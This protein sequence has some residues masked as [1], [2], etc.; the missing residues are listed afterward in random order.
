[1]ENNN[2]NAGQLA[3]QASE[4]KVIRKKVSLSCNVRLRP[5]LVALPNQLEEE[6]SY[7]VD[8]ILAPSGGPL[9]GV[10]GPLER[11][12]MPSIID[13]SVNDNT[14]N[15]HI[16]DYW[17]NFSNILPPDS[18]NK[19]DTT[20]GIVIK[21]TVILCSNFAID[22]FEKATRIEDKFTV[23]HN[24]L[25]NQAIDPNST[26]HAILDA[27]YYADFVKLAFIL[28]HS[29]IANRVEDREKSSKI[30]G[31]IYEK[32]IAVKAKRNEMDEFNNFL[33]NLKSLTE[34]NKANAILLSIEE[35]I[36]DTDTLEDKKLIIFNKG[37]LDATTRSKVNKLFTD[38]NWL[39]KYYINQGLQLNIL[40]CPANSTI[41]QYADTVIG[42]DVSTAALHLKDNAE[43]KVLL[44]IIKSK[45]KTE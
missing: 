40:K 3:K 31:Y 5:G 35:I 41:I 4:S 2:S 12:L 11:I 6:F 37:K 1:M 26:I 39:Y 45:L 16:K 42:N 17:C 29:K 25:E 20:Q 21:I 36:V 19:I 32:A 14:F 33:D 30:I 10:T 8:S 34:E 44:D 15:S 7:T 18:S 24:L 43:G 22:S 27:D 23:V 28:K 13:V 38:D 9:K